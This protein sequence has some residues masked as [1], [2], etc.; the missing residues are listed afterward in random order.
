[1][2][3]PR[4]PR[5]KPDG[6]MPL[7]EE[8]VG[9]QKGKRWRHREIRLSTGP[10]KHY[11]LRIN[12]PSGVDDHRANGRPI[13]SAVMHWGGLDA[14][15][16]TCDEIT[17]FRSFNAEECRWIAKAFLAAAKGL[18]ECERHGTKDEWFEPLGEKK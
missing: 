3:K 6:D 8:R 18:A 14:E 15:P 7:L 4:K 1:M 17:L 2:P 5:R 13:P 12:L 10:D 16:D 11:D 9:R